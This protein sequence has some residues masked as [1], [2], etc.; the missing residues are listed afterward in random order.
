M[1]ATFGAGN[2]IFCSR[3]ST[4][5]SGIVVSLSLQSR[6]RAML[7]TTCIYSG[8]FFNAPAISESGFGPR[9]P[10]SHLWVAKNLGIPRPKE[11]PSAGRERLSAGL[12]CRRA[13]VV[14]MATKPVRKSAAHNGRG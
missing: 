12:R 1:F 14:P 13:S 11:A 6:C 8:S 9:M 3:K 7:K 4:Q 5:F 2:V 10:Q